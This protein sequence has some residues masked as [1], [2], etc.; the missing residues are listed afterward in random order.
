LHAGGSIHIDH[1][2]APSLWDTSWLMANG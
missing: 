1:Y 2:A